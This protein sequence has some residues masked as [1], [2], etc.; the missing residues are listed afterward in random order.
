MKLLPNKSGDWYDVMTDCG[1]IYAVRGAQWVAYYYRTCGCKDAFVDNPL[2]EALDG[3]RVLSQ[4]K[5][6][7]CR[8]PT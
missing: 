7:D 1:N 5:C 4:K 6:S 3:A 8:G 2:S